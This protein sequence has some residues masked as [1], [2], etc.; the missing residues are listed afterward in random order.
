MMNKH[1]QGPSAFL[2]QNAESS[3]IAQWHETIGLSLRELQATDF[4]VNGKQ[5]GILVAAALDAVYA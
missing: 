2:R 3:R 1:V 4:V 5:Q